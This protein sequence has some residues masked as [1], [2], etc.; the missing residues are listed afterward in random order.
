MEVETED[1]DGGHDED[2]GARD[3]DK[4]NNIEPECTDSDQTEELEIEKECAAGV[5]NNNVAPTPRGR[6]RI[7]STENWKKNIRKMK[8]ARGA[9]YMSTAGKRIAAK[10]HVTIE[11]NC[12]LKCSE[13]MSAQRQ[14]QRHRQFSSME[15]WLRT[16]NCF[17]LCT[18]QSHESTCTIHKICQVSTQFFQV[19]L[20]ARPKRC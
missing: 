12:P 19:L 6:K 17:T 13:K 5:Y 8:R 2:T 10:E 15:D 3:S 14:H 4:N 18:S 20:F 16:S 11:R 9:E 7:R 1:F